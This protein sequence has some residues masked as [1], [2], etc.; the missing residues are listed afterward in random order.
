MTKRFENEA[1][2]AICG[3]PVWN[4]DQ[5]SIAM[6]LILCEPGRAP[7]QTKYRGFLPNDR[8]CLKC[9]PKV[10]ADRDAINNRLTA[11]SSRLA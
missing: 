6:P 7:E 9:K 11:A 2:C 4:S 5:H 10:I 3:D 8:V 1:C